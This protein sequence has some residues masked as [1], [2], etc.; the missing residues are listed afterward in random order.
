MPMNGMMN[1]NMM[2][3]PMMSGMQHQNLNMMEVAP[4][5]SLDFSPMM[6]SLQQK[7]DDPKKP[8]DPKEKEKKKEE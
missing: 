2:M 5:I 8:E 6:P 4:G 3:N 1:N 7:K